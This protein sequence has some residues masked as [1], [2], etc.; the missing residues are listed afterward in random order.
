MREME[1]REKQ[2]KYMKEKRGNDAQGNDRTRR[3]RKSINDTNELPKKRGE[4]REGKGRKRGKKGKQKEEK[5][6]KSV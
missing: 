5:S 4:M 1:Y 3:K 2:G 6:K